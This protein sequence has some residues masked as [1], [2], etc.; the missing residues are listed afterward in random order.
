MITE[1]EMKRILRNDIQIPGAVDRRISGTLSQ[2]EAYSAQGA[3]AL[4]SPRASRGFRRTILVA[5]VIAALA[6]GTT[7]AL[8][9]TGLLGAFFSAITSGS[10]SRQAIVEH[11]FVSEVTSA[12]P[13][14]AENGTATTGE[15]SL[16]LRAYY[17]DSKEIG[18]DFVLSNVGLDLSEDDLGNVFLN[19]GFRMEMDYS[20]GE[21][22]VWEQTERD[23]FSSR[24]FPGGHFVSDRANNIHEYKPG[25]DF[26]LGAA[27]KRIGD[28][29]YNI[30]LVVSFYQEPVQIGERLRLSLSELQF[31]VFDNNVDEPDVLTLKGDWTFEVQIDNIF[32]NTDALS[33]RPADG[34]S[35]RGVEITSV[36]VNPSIC[37][38][39]AQIDFEA[40]G[41]GNPDNA[42]LEATEWTTAEWQTAKMDMFELD[43]YA[44]SGDNVYRFET[45]AHT[46]V[47][48]GI[49]TCYFELASM[50]FDAPESIMLHFV[51]RN[52]VTLDI[53]LTLNVEP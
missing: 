19:N 31:V 18:F 2:I 44:S 29:E 37:R 47:A 11:G 53:P 26:L 43:V 49:V 13:I 35:V 51:N 24:T 6:A 20:S 32:Q 22:S 21:T 7:I 45:S 48:G 14:T 33:Y 27:A 8:A 25:Q 5:A 50:Y 12:S 17:I 40:S 9:S 41:L 1:R 16:I 46:D 38:I 30:S 4:P 3:V 34:F 52:G 23:N 10:P 39:E 42:N 15:N 36:T 28:G